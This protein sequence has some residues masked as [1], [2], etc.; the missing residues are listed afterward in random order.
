MGSKTNRAFGHG[1]AGAC[2]TILGGQLGPNELNDGQ[3]LRDI[4]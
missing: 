2:S 4:P 3:T 1:T